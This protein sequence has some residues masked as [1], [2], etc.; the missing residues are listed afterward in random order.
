[1]SEP[2]FDVIFRGDILPGFQLLQVKQDMRQLFKADEARIQ[3]L[4]TGGAVPLKRGVDAAAASR[5][6]QV[7]ARVGADARVVPAGS[8]K[9]APPRERRPPADSAR[10]ESLRERLSAGERAGAAASAAVGA[11]VAPEQSEA[12][13][14][15]ALL[16][17]GSDL[18]RPSERRSLQ[19][20]EVDVS[21]LSLR[22]QYGN[23]LDAD[24]VASVEP[25][26]VGDINFELGELGA[27]LLLDSEKRVVPATEMH[28]PE[29]GLA[30]T[31]SDLGQIKPGPPPP[32]PDTSGLELDTDS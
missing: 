1:M 25:A 20:L 19:A 28:L 26:R 29:V 4:F 27:D 32:P 11:T 7:L 18:L 3:A 9:V 12:G 8:V 17:A 2:L 21:A 15:W 14:D 6:Q 24:E 16:P 10:R 30:P 5:Y 31:G 23:L 13:E 22:P